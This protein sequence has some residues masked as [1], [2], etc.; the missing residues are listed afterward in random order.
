MYTLQSFGINPASV[1]VGVDGKPKVDTFLKLLKQH[2]LLQ[3]ES[4]D[5]IDKVI[6]PAQ[7]TP[8]D[9]SI[10][11]PLKDDILLGRGRHCQMHTGNI[12]LQQ[13]IDADLRSYQEASSKFEKSCVVQRMVHRVRSEGG[14]FLKYNAN[15]KVW[16]LADETII[17]DTT[18]ARYRNRIRQLSDRPTAAVEIEA[19]AHRHQVQQNMLFEKL[20]QLQEEKARLTQLQ[21]SLQRGAIIQQDSIQQSLHRWDNTDSQQQLQHQMKPYFQQT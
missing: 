17:H 16:V 2:Q 8:L 20:R 12:A 13:M 21:Q 4:A 3:T 14:R 6:Q 19:T 5:K 9:D 18:S 11:K 15:A 7:E 1:P 10:L